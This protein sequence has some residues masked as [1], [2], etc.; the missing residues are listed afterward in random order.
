MQNRIKN[1]LHNIISGKSQVSF[2]AI[3]QTIASYL[4]NGSKTGS[5]TES[6]KQIREQE[7]KRLENFIT[8]RNLWIKEIDFS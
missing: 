7:T 1:E 4:N 2:G 8:N 6:S 5:E 3:I